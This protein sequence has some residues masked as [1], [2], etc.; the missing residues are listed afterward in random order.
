MTF[1]QAIAAEMYMAAAL[2]FHRATSAEL[3]PY[4]TPEQRKEWSDHYRDL[5]EDLE[6][7]AKLLEG[8]RFQ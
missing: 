5:G 3:N 1:E 8:G 7:N 4:L 2:S 6:R